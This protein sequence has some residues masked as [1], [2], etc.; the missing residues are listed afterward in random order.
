[1]C[2][3]DTPGDGSVAP[4]R[5]RAII[6]SVKSSFLRRSGVRNAP[7]KALS[8][9]P[10]AREPVWFLVWRSYR[11][12]DRDRRCDSNSLERDGYRVPPAR[13]PSAAGPPGGTPHAAQIWVAEPPAA[14]IFSLAAAEKAC[15]FTCRATPPSSPVASTL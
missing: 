12:L 8:T 6:A 15:A 9:V 4:S 11:P 5:Y 13:M 14:S 7:V 3:Y 1:M 10:P 2:E